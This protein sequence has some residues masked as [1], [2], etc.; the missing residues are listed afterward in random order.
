VNRRAYLY[1]TR[2]PCLKMLGHCSSKLAA[3][4][5]AAGVH[6][7]N[8]NLMGSADSEPTSE[9]VSALSLPALPAVGP[10]CPRAGADSFY[11]RDFY[12]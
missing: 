5:A 11:V 6:S 8:P 3:A 4:V 12:Q 1:S 10:S 7:L 2:S 9:V